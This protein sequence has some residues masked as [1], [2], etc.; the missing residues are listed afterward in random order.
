MYTLILPTYNEKENLKVYLP[1]LETLFHL[2][3]IDYEIIIVDDDSPDRTWEWVQEYGIKNQNVRVIRRIQE[4]GLSSAVLTGMASA[5]GK[6]LGVMDA[7]MQH[8]ESIIPKMLE[9]LKEND[10]VIGSRRVGD[11]SYGE[12]NLFRRILSFGATILAKIL[13][14]IPSTDPMSGFFV[15]KREVFENS[16]DKLNPLGFKILLEFL[17]KNPKIKVM[18]VGYSFRKREFGETKLSGIVMQQYLFALIDLRFGKYFSSEF[19]K[20]GIIGFT[21]VFV[22]LVGQWLYVNVSDYSNPNSEMSKILIP[23]FAV[24]FGFEVSV[25]SN[26]I[27]NNQW[28]FASKR[29]TKVKEFIFGLFKF[30]FV[31]LVGFFIQYSCWL[32]IFQFCNTYYPEFFPNYITYIAN[33]I[34]ILIAT[35]TNYQLNRSYTWD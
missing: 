13:L 35:V 18:E 24:A 32:F 26:Y 15:L 17:A 2:N 16:K 34:G 33:L 12:M 31:S 14:P 25:I 11:G 22:N 20:Y 9:A 28:T 27:L 6:Y 19:V 21:G 3:N 7:D 5:R 1:K 23:S 29:K 8:D 10:L 30:N 4:K